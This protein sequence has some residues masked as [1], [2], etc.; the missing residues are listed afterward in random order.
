MS[1]YAYIGFGSNQGDRELKFREALAALAEL[2]VTTVE[3]HSGL[4]E[5]EPIGLADNGSKFL[6]AAVALKTDLSPVELMKMLRVIE[7]NLGKSPTHRSDMSR[8]IDL[9]LLLYEDL[10]IS[11][12]GLEIPHPRMHH[13]AFVLVPLAEIAAEVGHPV[14][15]SAIGK[16]LD[17]LPS[18][19][20]AKCVLWT[21]CRPDEN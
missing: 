13:R 17:C 5:T 16:I 15:R 21:P 12:D 11:E 9:D 3:K 18:S 19:E 2:P 14:L 1:R 6:N 10:H 7:L 8:T 20:R 4:Y